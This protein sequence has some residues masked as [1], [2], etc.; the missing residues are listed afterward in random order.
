MNLKMMWT[1]MT[2]NKKIKTAGELDHAIKNNELILHYQL[3]FNDDKVSGMEA[4]L[5]WKHPES[6]RIISA[7][8][9][10]PFIDDRKQIHQIDKWVINQVASDIAKMGRIM[11]KAP[12]VSINLSNQEVFSEDLS[13]L[14]EFAMKKHFLA[15]N[16]LNIETSE[17]LLTA[18]IGESNKIIQN[19]KK[20]GVCTI[21]DHFGTG[22]MSLSNLQ[23][24]GVN[25]I[26]IDKSFIDNI[27]TN[28]ADLEMCRTIIQLAKSLK[29][30]VIAEGVETEAQKRILNAE[31]CRIIQGYVYTQ[32]AP[33]DKV[34]QLLTEHPEIQ[35]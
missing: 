15:G 30:Q 5:R 29:L 12:R 3:Q 34:I 33:I 21:I 4:L 22:N 7:A 35:M 20:L 18:D 14:I 31:G 24:L 2:I 11:T 25:A 1:N 8:D 10:M 32:P 23:N 17:D 13:N 16:T 9:F 27:T 19:L 26:K 28:H 6:K